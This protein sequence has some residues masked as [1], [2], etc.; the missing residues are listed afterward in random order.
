MAKDAYPRRESI[1]KEAR[2]KHMLSRESSSKEVHSRQAYS[3]EAYSKEANSKETYSREAHSREALSVANS[4]EGV[5]TKHNIKI[6]RMKSILTKTGFYMKPAVKPDENGVYK[7]GHRETFEERRERRKKAQDK[8]IQLV[9]DM[10]ID[11]TME[12]YKA[13]MPSIKVTGEIIQDR[14]GQKSLQNYEK[15]HAE[16]R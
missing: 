14:K 13:K 1:I 12:Y 4:D 3:R 7:A 11:G 2:S 8:V 5:Q 15:K 9:D 10:D 6:S 16:K